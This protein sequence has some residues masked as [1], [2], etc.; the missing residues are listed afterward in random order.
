ML[1]WVRCPPCG[2]SIASTV[3]PGCSSA[4]YAAR[5]A[6]RA[7][8]RLQVGVLGAEQ[9]LGPRDRRSPR[10]GRPCAAAVVAPAGVA[11]GVLVGQRRAERGQ[12]RRRGEV[13][14]RDQLQP[15]AQAVQLA[16][17]HLGDLRVR[18]LAARRSPAP[19]TGWRS[20]W[21]SARCARSRWPTLPARPRSPWR[22]RRSPRRP[23]PSY[24]TPGRRS[25]RRCTGVPFGVDGR[26]P[27]QQIPDSGRTA[28]LAAPRG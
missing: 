27:V 28:G 15:A 22:P 8:V 4:A 20:G 25:L 6:L 16:E 9:L 3:S 2:R 23:G 19:R 17:H 11:L 21:W 12:H 5:L 7:A 10:P 14:A 13:L 1:P 26:T 18:L 24:G